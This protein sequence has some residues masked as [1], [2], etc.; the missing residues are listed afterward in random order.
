MSQ[1]IAGRTLEKE[2][3]SKFSGESCGLTPAMSH[4]ISLRT[5]SRICA[6]LLN[7]NHPHSFGGG[8]YFPGACA[9]HSFL[10]DR[11]CVGR[12]PVGFV[13][14]SGKACKHALKTESQTPLCLPVLYNWPL[15]N[16]TKQKW[17]KGGWQY[18]PN[19]ISCKMHTLVRIATWVKK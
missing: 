1:S 19:G 6:A 10:N 11:V 2:V 5:G 7:R 16:A 17:T 8:E 3:R 12:R 4:Y 14:P 15:Q 9:I 18:L 13:C